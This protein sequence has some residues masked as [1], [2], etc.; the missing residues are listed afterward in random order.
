M[1][2]A[3]R[4]HGLGLF[5]LEL[6]KHLP[7]F[8]RE[9]AGKTHLLRK[10]LRALRQP[11]LLIFDHYEDVAQNKIVTD[12]LNQQLLMEVDTS[13]GLAVIVAG[14]AI[15]DFMSTAWRQLA[16][17]LPL[18][19]ICDQ[20]EWEPW[21]ARRYPGLRDKGADLSTVIMCAEGKPG[22]VAALCEAIVKTDRV[23][24]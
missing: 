23:A 2:C 24:E 8:S 22:M 9:G 12:W 3:I 20:Q 10:D 16:R 7:N 5:E 4:P 21:I 11:V 17:Q 14:R 18:G 15:P 6:G 1:L 19:P 13:L